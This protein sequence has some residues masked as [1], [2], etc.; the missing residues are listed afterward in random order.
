[1]PY[2]VENL[3]TGKFVE[4]TLNTALRPVVLLPV[5]FVSELGSGADKH[6]NDSGAAAAIMLLKAYF[7]VEMTPDE[8]YTRFGIPGDPYLSVVQLRNT[9]GSLGLLTDFRA[10]LSTQDLFGALAAGKPAI[11]PWS[12]KNSRTPSDILA[13]CLL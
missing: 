6:Q 3:D 11:I 4:Y 5:P 12:Q 8:F 2:K 7:N 13:P 1:M 10:G 9:M